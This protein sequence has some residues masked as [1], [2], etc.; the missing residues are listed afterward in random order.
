MSIS[1]KYKCWKGSFLCCAIFFYERHFGL[2]LDA[3]WTFTY[4][5]FLKFSLSS[6]TR[7]IVASYNSFVAIRS[8]PEILFCSES[9]WRRL[10]RPKYR[11]LINLHI[12]YYILLLFCHLYTIVCYLSETGRSFC[13]SPLCSLLLMCPFHSRFQSSTPNCS[14]K[15]D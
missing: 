1:R 13:W 2:W 14:D 8:K 5:K 9:V 3:L 11:H 4:H 7:S 15:N 6:L 10:H 12:L